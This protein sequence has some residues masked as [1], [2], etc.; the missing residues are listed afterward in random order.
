M[1]HR[2]VR[3]MRYVVKLPG[4][5]EGHCEL[6]AVLDHAAYPIRS[7]PVGHACKRSDVNG[8]PE[9]ALGESARHTCL[10]GQAHRDMGGGEPDLRARLVKAIAQCVR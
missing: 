9:P 7:L 4:R 2:D 1:A 3:S 6:V 10:L 5:L 8:A